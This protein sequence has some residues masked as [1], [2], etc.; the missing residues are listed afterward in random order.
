[1]LGGFLMVLGVV[2]ALLAG[3]FSAVAAIL[4]FGGLVTL[5]IGIAKRDGTS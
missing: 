1:M 4:F 5:I 3:T 2:F